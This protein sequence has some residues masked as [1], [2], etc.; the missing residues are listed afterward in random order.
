MTSTQT[1]QASEDEIRTA[2]AA[3]GTYD[4]NNPFPLFAMV[5]ERGAARPVTL[6]D[7][8]DA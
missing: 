3:W 8:H 1:T 6:A 5:R 7:G 4:R 2:L